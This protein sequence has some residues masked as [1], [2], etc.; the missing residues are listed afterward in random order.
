MTKLHLAA[1]GLA[2]LGMGVAHAQMPQR[3]ATKAG[4][5]AVYTIKHQ[6]DRQVSEETVTVT[7]VSAGRIQTL[8]KLSDRPDVVPGLY[9]A[10]WGPVQSGS[11]GARFEPG[12]KLLQFPLEVGRT[13]EQ[14]YQVFAPNGWHSQ[15]EMAS[16]V[17]ATERL[18]T[19]AGEF[20]TYRI[21]ASGYRSTASRMGVFRILEKLWYAPA[22]D[23]MVRV[24]YKETRP[25]GADNIAE[26]K[27]F[28]P[29]R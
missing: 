21:E 8:H 27:S 13:W 25:L 24:E 15:V 2:W 22:I 12:V 28:T 4:D 20:D 23:R 5:V 9:S 1:L 17:A 3:G 16:R 11:S 10:D 7:A 14:T 18:A 6:A 19:P 26:L 29:A